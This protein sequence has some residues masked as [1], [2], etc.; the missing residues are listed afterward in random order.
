M[1]MTMWPMFSCVTESGFTD[2]PALF[3]F[4]LLYVLGIMLLLT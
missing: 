3:F 2:I 4:F 1:M